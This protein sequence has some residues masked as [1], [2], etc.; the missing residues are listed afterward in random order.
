MVQRR[1]PA[2]LAA[3]VGPCLRAAA[4]CGV[5]A[6]AL[7]ALAQVRV[8]VDGAALRASK[9]K[10]AG[11]VAVG[12]KTVYEWPDVRVMVQDGKVV[13]VSFLTADAYAA[14]VPAA[15]AITTENKALSADIRRK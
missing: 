4:L 10:P 3:A 7:P 15:G 12:K 11:S 8:G 1:T 14:A 13:K 2:A 6:L 9:G 5:L